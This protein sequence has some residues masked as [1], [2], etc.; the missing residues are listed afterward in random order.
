MHNIHDILA[1]AAGEMGISLTAQALDR[2]T[3]YSRELSFWNEKMSLVSLK[4]PHDVT[5]HLIDSLSPA[6]FIEDG[7]RLLDIGTGAGLPGI[8]LTIARGPLHV[9]LIDASRKKS[10]FLKSVIRTLD[11][12]SASV[13]TGRAESLADNPHYRGAFDIVI[14]RATFKI[15][16]L[17][18][19]GEPFLAPEGTLIAMKGN[20]PDEELARATDSLIQTGLALTGFHKIVLPVTGEERTLLCFSRASS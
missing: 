14:S 10:S 13:V 5:K 8:P 1:G 2:F 19:V 9:T 6:R 12:R 4:S 3:A 7:N 16:Q 15:A 20:H 18:T 11:L 17:L